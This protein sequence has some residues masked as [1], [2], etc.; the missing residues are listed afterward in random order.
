MKIL[1]LGGHGYLG[2]H[3]VT[4]LE[5]D[6]EL[7]LT[8]VVPIESPHETRRVDV[9]DLAQVR[10]AAQGTDAIIN[11]SVS[12]THR[13]R[14]FDVNTIGTMNA[15]SVAVELG[16]ERFINT[17]PRYTLVGPAYLDTDFGLQEEIPSHAGTLLYALSKSV[18]QEICRVYAQQ[19]P[20]HVLTMIVSSFIDAEPP[21]DWRG[22][23]RGDMNP[24]AV[25]YADAAR[26][27]RCALEVDTTRLPSRCEAFFVTVD[28]PQGQCLGGKA[29]DLLGW[30]PQDNLEAWYRRVSTSRPSS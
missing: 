23:W 13:Q 14:A 6:H 24:F 9:S 22:D 29:R 10:A 18:G 25:T 4:E 11:C 12:R 21:V 1:L 30:Q 19:H 7:V 15:V 27:I 17:G 26:A 5:R 8:D 16:H 20:I 28:L 3:L 2:P